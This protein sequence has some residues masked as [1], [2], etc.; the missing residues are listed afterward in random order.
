M[1]LE[2]IQ[3]PPRCVQLTNQLGRCIEVNKITIPK[4]TRLIP[5]LGH[6]AGW[7]LLSM[8]C[9]VLYPRTLLFEWYRMIG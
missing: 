1:A 6:Q 4:L 8:S 2:T 3:L 5:K 9:H 7:R